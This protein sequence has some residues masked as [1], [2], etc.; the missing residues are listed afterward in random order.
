[1][2]LP[3]LF[4]LASASSLG[5]AVQEHTAGS[6]RHH[7]P[8]LDCAPPPAPPT[9]N[10]SSFRANLASAL[11]GLPSMV[12]AASE[13]IVFLEP[14]P[15]DAGPDRVFARGGCFGQPGS[16]GSSWPGACLACLKTAARELAGGCQGTRRAGAWRDGCFM[17]YADTGAS[18]AHEDAFRGWFYGPGSSTTLPLA[19]GGECMVYDA[20]GCERCLDDLLRAAPPLGWLWRLR[21]G[22]EV[23]VVSYTCFLSFKIPPNNQSLSE[24]RR[25][26]D[27]S[28]QC[29]GYYKDGED[30]DFDQ[31][32]LRT[33]AA[34]AKFWAWF[35]LAAEALTIGVLFCLII[36]TLI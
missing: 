16:G 13:G 17:A 31:S 3:F 30:G 28:L 10:S 35:M 18:S 1:M 14:E 21:G 20:A 23:V 8:L 32:L 15:V 26:H 4:F 29:F 2:L 34:F 19:Y 11:A 6:D 7:L 22:D 27:L 36:L 24:F 33:P 9:H 12:A 25:I 5:V